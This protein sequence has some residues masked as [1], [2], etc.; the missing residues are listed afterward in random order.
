MSVEVAAEVLLLIE[1][2]L[3]SFGRQAALALERAPDSHL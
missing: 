2:A 1:S 3:Q